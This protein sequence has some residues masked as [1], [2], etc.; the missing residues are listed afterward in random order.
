MSINYVIATYNGFT[1]R[2][3]KYPTPENILK[4]HLNKLLS[5]QHKLGQI[6]I[7]K[8]KANNYYETYY[9]IESIVKK[10]NIPVCLIDCENYGYS[11]GQWLTAYELF[12][13]Q[14]DYYFFMEDDYCGNI[15][16]FD[17]KII[18]IYLNKFENNTGILCSSVSGNK[19][20]KTEGGHPIHFSGLVFLSKTTLNIL[21]NN[22]IFE[23]NPKKWL[24]LL[25][26]KYAKS[27]NS[28]YKKNNLG[29]YYQLTFSHLLT[30]SG[31]E[32][33]EYLG[34]SD[35]FPYWHDNSNG[36]EV[37]LFKQNQRITKDYTFNDIYNTLIVPV[38]L[39]DKE[40]ILLN[41]G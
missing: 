37:I 16:N 30:L 1:K 40:N 4:C 5:I 32:H 38:Q 22:H 2:C 10:F 31:I 9:D 6:T 25:D 20:H 24:D 3:H 7:M 34:K 19:N 36:G 26:E 28:N 13:D 23:N 14:F 35:I 18:E 12:K 21:Y 41:I 15:D 8:A 39:S 33:K 17:T 27:F 11:G 29:G